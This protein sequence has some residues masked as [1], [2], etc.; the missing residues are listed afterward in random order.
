MA[1]MELLHCELLSSRGWARAG[2]KLFSWDKRVTLDV[3]RGG[4]GLE[5]AVLGRRTSAV[6]VRA[7]Q[8]REERDE[9]SPR[10]NGTA[11]QG[12]EERRSGKKSED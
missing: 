12:S 5:V 2:E 4:L 9:T 3:R 8:Q 11:G 10:S 6:R 7:E 1:G